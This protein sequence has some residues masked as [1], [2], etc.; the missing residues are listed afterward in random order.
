MDAS[1]LR[2]VEAIGVWHHLPTIVLGC[3]RTTLGDKFTALLHA[4]FLEAGHSFTDLHSFV[5]SIVCCTSDFGVEF[6]MSSIKP[7]SLRAALPW[8]PIEYVQAPPLEVDDH[9]EWDGFD[10]A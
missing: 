1:L 4:C 6:G 3:G 10:V 9:Q 7:M 8:V 2:E 5:A